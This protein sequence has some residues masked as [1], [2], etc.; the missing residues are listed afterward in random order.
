VGAI[1]GPQAS[2][3]LLAAMQDTSAP[4][5]A[6]AAM[7][8]GKVADRG[9]IVPLQ[10]ALSDADP[11]VRWQAVRALGKVGDEATVSLLRSLLSDQSEVFGASVAQAAQEAIRE[12]EARQEKCA[13]SGRS[14]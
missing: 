13:R 8:L 3:A 7:A 4:V 9:A 2:A 6:S 5:R 14:L 1:G 11:A 10:H 12:I